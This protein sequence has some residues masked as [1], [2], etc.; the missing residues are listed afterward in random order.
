MDMKKILGLIEEGTG[1]RPQ[2]FAIDSVKNLPAL[3]YRIYRT[4]DNGSKSQ[5]RLECRITADSL[6]SLLEKEDQLKDSLVTVA[7]TTKCGC[8]IAVNGGGTL[9]DET[10]GFPQQITYFDLTTR[11]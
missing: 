4:S 8:S 1:L 10:T 7:D 6:V 11:S 2:P 5:W 9:L 3:S